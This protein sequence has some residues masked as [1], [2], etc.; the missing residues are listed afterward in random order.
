MAGQFETYAR[1]GGVLHTAGGIDYFAWNNRR[2]PS[3]AYR[4]LVAGHI[5][6]VPPPPPL[7]PPRVA[8]RE[9]RLHRAPRPFIRGKSKFDN[10]LV[11]EVIAA[12]HRD[13]VDGT[14]AVVAVHIN[15]DYRSADPAG[16]V[17]RAGE[18]RGGT[19]WQSGK[20]SNWQIFHNVNLAMSEGSYRNQDGTTMHA[21]WKLALCT[22]PGGAAVCL[23]KR[24]RPGLCP[25]EH[26]AFALQT[27]TDPVLMNDANGQIVR[28]GA[29]RNDD[30]RDFKIAAAPADK[31]LTPAVFGLPFTLEQLLPIVARNNHV[32]VTG[33]SYNYRDMLMNFVCNLRRLG[34]HSQLIIATWDTDMYEYG[35][36]LGLPVFLFRPAG[37]GFAGQDM[38]YGSQTFRAVTK[39]KSQVVLRILQ[40]GYDVTWTDSDIVWFK[41]PISA[42]AAAGPDF[43]VQSN[44]P[45]DERAA[46]GPLRINSGFY[47]V[48]S[49]PLATAAMEQV[50]L[51]A[52]E[53]KLTEQPSF[54]K[55]LCGGVQ[56][57]FR[58]GHNRCVYAPEKVD[59]GPPEELVVEFLDRELYPNGAYTKFWDDPDIRETDELMILHNNWIKGA[60]NKIQRLVDR[61][62]WF[63]N[64]RDEICD[65]GQAP[66]FAFVPA[67]RGGGAAGR[68]GGHACLTQSPPPPP[69]PG[70]TGPWRATA[71]SQVARRPDMVLA[72][73]PIILFCYSRENLRAC[74]PV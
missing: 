53:S 72:R 71:R 17:V 21:P 41:S 66:Q 69:T 11:H 12:G 28:C 51:H 23:L 24:A 19:F 22:E 49:R 35:F 40:L 30:P 2:L 13:V 61:G 46:N 58:I 37:G 38:R 15:H 42:L 33:A 68:R 74:V 39:L 18:V 16:A 26:G 20:R 10:W 60:G 43:V 52:A 56:G 48:R 8:P 70:S 45:P 14:E 1:T 9:C 54:Y 50:V 55:V 29:I 3:G 5:P 36:R 31:P 34:A 44:A 65:Y 25:C 64:R 6:W 67:R 4:P 27:Q 62:L 57:Q 63:F 47:R 59:A 73:G 32:I 7:F